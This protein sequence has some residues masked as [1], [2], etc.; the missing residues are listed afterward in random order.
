MNDQYSPVLASSIAFSSLKNMD[1]VLDA[2]MGLEVFLD[3]PGWY[4]EVTIEN[5]LWKLRRSFGE[6]PLS[7]H[8]SIAEGL[9]LSEPVHSPEQQRAMASFHRTIVMAGRLG[10]LHVVVHTHGYHRFISDEVRPVLQDRMKHSLSVLGTWGLQA[11]TKV[12]VENIGTENQ[13]TLLYREKEF[14]QLFNDV[15]E[16]YSLI[17][18][19]HAFLN[20]WDVPALI[21]KLGSRLVAL[22]IHDNHGQTDEHLPLGQGAIDWAPIADAIGETAKPPVLVLEYE[23]KVNRDAWASLQQGD[24][25]LRSW[26][27]N[28]NDHQ[29]YAFWRK[30]A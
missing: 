10:A 7:F 30:H 21:R 1:I 11:K 9:D 25:L 20:K 24:I 22:H 27:G 17:D 18:V 12:V 19:G 16:I 13:G 4:D 26:Q 5:Y 23:G 3:M 28:I 2:G 6:F 8:A 29:D 14:V 15:P